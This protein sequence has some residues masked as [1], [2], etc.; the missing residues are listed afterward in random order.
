MTTPKIFNNED[1]LKISMAKAIAAIENVFFD[2]DSGAFLSPPRHYFK[3]DNGSIA[4]TIGGNKDAGVLGFR[5]YDT[6][7]SDIDHQ[8]FV[9]VFDAQSGALKGL[10]FG[11]QLGAL[12]TGAIGGV[13]IKYLSRVE[14]SCV[15]LIGTGLQARSQLAAACAVRDITKIRVFGRNEERRKTF[16]DEMSEKLGLNVEPVSTN[17]EAVIDAD[18]VITAT[19]SGSP[20]FDPDWVRPGTHITTVGPKFI[21]RN[22][23]DATVADKS[24]W[25]FTDSIQQLKSYSTPHFL[26]KTSHYESIK[27]LGDLINKKGS[28]DRKNEDITLFLS[29]GLSGTEPI[30]ANLLF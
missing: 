21:G 28:F 6:F 23:I 10:V 9:T 22:E 20:V 17:K 13:A 27:S 14:S 24:N 26:S 19:T 5:V 29:V 8:Q 30:I 18:I 1:V 25:I 15:G 4:F 7:K 12:R 2:L 3:N 16:A 11:E